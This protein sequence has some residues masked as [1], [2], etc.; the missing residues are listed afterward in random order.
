MEKKILIAFAITLVLITGV[1]LVSAAL[2]EENTPQEDK[3]VVVNEAAEPT[4]G[5]S[6]CGGTCGGSCGIP[7]CGCG[8]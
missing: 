3:I 4:C 6:T 8:R 1:L 5:P 2:P 7:T